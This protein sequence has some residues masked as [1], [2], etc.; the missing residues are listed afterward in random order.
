MILGDAKLCRANQLSVELFPLYFLVK[1][2]SMGAPLMQGKNINDVYYASGV[3][4]PKLN[5]A[6]KASPIDY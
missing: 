5:V 1:D 2:L 3:L 6:T 4:L